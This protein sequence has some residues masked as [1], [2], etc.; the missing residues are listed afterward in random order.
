MSRD[1]L[2]A[3]IHIARKELGLDD[4]TYRDLLE[5]VT[6]ARSSGD[7]SEPDRQKVIR[8]FR[9]LGWKGGAS[10]RKRSDKAYVR[11]VFALWGELKRTGVW[12]G[13]DIGSLRRF[14]KN[15]TG[16]DDPEWLSWPQAS[17][18][19]EALKKIKERG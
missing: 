13:E 15:M 18:V 11:K 1:P 3:R 7:L 16:C 2:L 14:V 10:R 8:A 5:R 9:R 12:R 4:D 19:I 6:G 17:Q